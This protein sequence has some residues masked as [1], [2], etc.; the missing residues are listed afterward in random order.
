MI[1]PFIL[2]LDIHSNFVM[3]CSWFF[4]ILNMLTIIFGKPYSKIKTN[5]ESRK[6]I[7]NFAIGFVIPQEL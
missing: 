5:F 1:L 7:G 2:P 6:L 4:T 3:S